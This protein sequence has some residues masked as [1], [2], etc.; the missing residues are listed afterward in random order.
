MVYTI[1]IFI[2]CLQPKPVFIIPSENA[3][4]KC[5][6]LILANVVYDS[7]EKPTTSEEIMHI[8]MKHLINTNL[9]YLLCY[10]VIIQISGFVVKV[11]PQFNRHLR[12]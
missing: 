6:F 5:L 8:K 9:L 7:T 12:I 3:S 1:Y 2:K 10:C 11:R 4:N